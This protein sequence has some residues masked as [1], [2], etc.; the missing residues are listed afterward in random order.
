M[1]IPDTNLLVYAYNLRAPQNRD[2]GL[3]LQRLLEGTET[4]GLPWEVIVSFIRIMT[5][6]QVVTGLQQPVDVVAVVE[7]WLSLD[8]VAVVEPG[9][10]HLELVANLLTAVGEGDQQVPDAHIAAI[11]IHHDAE[12]HTNDHGFARFPGL[13]L[14]FPIR[15]PT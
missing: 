6:P 13:R 9:P 12:L 15:S 11:A 5:K 1:I 4:V 2:A 8:N 7:Q 3:W 14:T 10:R